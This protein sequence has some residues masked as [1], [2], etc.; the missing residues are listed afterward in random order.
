MDEWLNVSRFPPQVPH[1]ELETWLVQ[2]EPDPLSMGC[3]DQA[4]PLERAPTGDNRDQIGSRVEARGGP[5]TLQAQQV[6]L[7]NNI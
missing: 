1:A 7:F 2:R 6:Q 5:G 3:P 4:S